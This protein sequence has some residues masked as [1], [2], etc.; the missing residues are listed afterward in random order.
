MDYS[1]FRIEKRKSMDEV[2]MMGEHNYRHKSVLN[3]D[4]KKTHLN[5][6]LVGTTFI[7]QD[8]LN[9]Y[10]RLNIDLNSGLRK[11]G[12]VAVEVLLAF[13][14]SWVRNADG[15]YKP[16]AKSKIHQWVNRSISWLK[17]NFGENV[18]NG[19]VHFD[20]TN[21]H[22]HCTLAVAYWNER[23]QKYRLSADKFF[24]NKKK[25]SDLQTSYA[26][27]FEDLGLHR[28]IDGSKATHKK[29]SE[30]YRELEEANAISEQLSLESPGRSPAKLT[31]WKS[32]L[33]ELSEEVSE[34]HKKRYEELAS[35]AAYWERM[36]HNLRNEQLSNQAIVCNQKPKI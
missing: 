34:K 5:K 7:E 19:V 32:A 16:D 6:C 12:V 2:R 31:K 3:A 15:S 18:V 23:W 4:P 17:L 24:G 10:N 1:I 9:Y 27:M 28:G 33:D 30:F 11:N 13:S 29:I 35:E 36:Y 21:I 14:P 20:E 22:L 25:L 26:A 8:L